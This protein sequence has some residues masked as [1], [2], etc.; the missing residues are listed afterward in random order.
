MGNP[1]ESTV[2][3]QAERFNEPQARRLLSTASH[4]DKLLLEIEEILS[5]SSSG[6]FPKYKNPL[7][8]VQVRVVRDYIK[9][10]RQQ[11]IRVLADLEVNLPEPRFDSTFSIKVM[12]QFIQIALEEIAP[13]RLGGYGT[14]PHSLVKPLAG[15]IQEMIGI[16]RQMD[17][18]LSQR[19]EADLSNR[20]LQLRETDVDVGLLK[21]LG[22]LVERHSLVEFRQPLAQLVEKIEFPTY[23]IA[24]FGRVS[25]GKSSLLNAIIGM[26]LLPIGVTPITAVP[27]RIKNGPNSQLLVWSAEGRFAKYSTGQLPE[28]VTEAQNPGNEKRVARLLVEIPLSILPEEVLLVDTPGLG[29][30]AL[31]GAAETLAYLPNCDLGV[32]L[33]DAAS[34]LQ[35]DDVATVDA[36]RTASVP[37]LVVLSKADLVPEQDRERLL[38]YTRTQ[39]GR[40]LRMDI[41]VALLSSRPELASLLQEWVAHQISPRVANARQLSG[42][43][44][45]RKTRSLARGILRALEVS[46]KASDPRFDKLS[47]EFKAAETQLRRAASLIED[48]WRQCVGLTDQIRS[49]GEPALDRLAESATTVWQED[50]SSSSLDNAWIARKIDQ[51]AQTEAEHLAS[52]V[53][54]TAEE[55]TAALEAAA[56][57]IT[58]GE[59]E[60]HFTLRNFVKEMPPADFNYPPIRLSRPRLLRM[61]ATLAQRSTRN[62][63]EK[64]LGGSIIEFFTSYGRILE[65]WFRGTLDTI[66]REFEVHADVYRAQ[67]QRLTAG[68]VSQGR[69]PAER[70]LEEVSLLRRE[71]ELEE[72][73]QVESGVPIA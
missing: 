23:E 52:L 46:A 3:S 48:T 18:Y 5:A 37:A 57:V 73:E 6:G 25:T 30:L 51:L 50:P 42:E 28:F 34:N 1:T 24:F 67:L 7:A 59:Q 41:D 14:V 36:L 16:V 66:A 26:N 63:I 40:Q 53:Q 15:G 65:V 11:I 19:I 2:I 69:A 54:N 49:A 47:D 72:A 12:L 33:V 13:Q 10:L 62:E 32:V 64:Q 71:L 35:A 55:L 20:L 29:S 43:S 21:K 58:T 27:T 44:N 9:R 39:L 68:A 56:S 45:Q 22:D 4:I 61:S 31:E 70:I 8:P 17:F 60:D 38:D